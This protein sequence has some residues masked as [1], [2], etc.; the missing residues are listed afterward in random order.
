MKRFTFAPKCQNVTAPVCCGDDI[1]DGLITPR[2]IKRFSAVYAVV[3]ERVVEL[4]SESVLNHLLD[5]VP[6]CVFPRGERHKSLAR[7][8]RILSWLLE[9][10]ADRDSLLLGIGGGVVTDI[11]GFAASCYMRGIAYIAVPTTLLAQVDAAIGGKTAVNLHSTKNVIGSFYAPQM[12]ICDSRFLSSLRTEQIK[13][14]LVE[15]IKVFAASDRRLFEKHAPNLPSLIDRQDLNH[16]IA[17]AIRAKLVIV[18]GDPFEEG[19]R[20]VLNFGHTTG[21]AVEAVAG[22]SHGK[23]IAFGMLVALKLS[24]RHSSLS[25][26]DLNQIWSAI[27]A[28]YDHFD[29]AALDAELLWEKI[30][31]DKKRSGRQINFVLLPRCG[32]FQIVTINFAQFKRALSETR[33]RISR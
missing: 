16:L 8:Q 29:A 2:Y 13:Q 27:K 22:W 20:R 5:G 23:S 7:L 25:G 14:G 33:E 1:I 18:N 32:A 31:H 17:D 3:D 6:V 21:H 24:Q 9:N 28:L 4:Y 26:G 12:V 10:E 30:K 15:A 11:A 19:L